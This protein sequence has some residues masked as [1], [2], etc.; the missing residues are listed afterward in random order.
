MQAKMLHFREQ[1]QETSSGKM[2]SLRYKS[3]RKKYKVMRCLCSEI[4]KCSQ[5]K[6]LNVCQNKAR[7]QT[8]KSG[9][10]WGEA[11]EMSLMDL[12]FQSSRKGSLNFTLENWV[13]KHQEAG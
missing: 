1:R 12:L 3:N 11:D 8:M 2:K 4:D 9:C 7:V 13:E 5:N 6:I 10:G